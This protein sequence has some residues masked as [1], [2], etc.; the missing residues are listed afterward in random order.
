MRVS[1]A[2]VL[3][4]LMHSCL[5]K[6]S[7]QGNR[8]LSSV[9]KTRS[10]RAFSQSCGRRGRS[11]RIVGGG[12]ASLAEWPWQVSLRQYSRGGFKHKCG[13]ALI[14]Q[15]WIITAAHCVKGRRPKD[16]LVRLG[17][18]NSRSSRDGSRS[19]E[20]DIAM[21]E[22]SP[23][24]YTKTTGAICL[25]SSSS[26][27]VG[28]TGTVTGWGRTSERGSTASVLREVQVPIISNS[29]CERMYRATGQNEYIP[30]IFLCAGTR[31]RD[32]CDGDSGGPLVVKGRNGRYSLEGI[33]S[34]GIGCGARN[35]PGVYTRI[36]Q[37]RTWIQNVLRS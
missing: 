3:A 36:A 18:Y 28:R 20:N 34:W 11:G 35:R 7:H 37:F 17:E 14:S 33:I 15:R 32:S 26:S 23:V 16:L 4:V 22:V 29:Q 9:V 24:K 8:T 31:G 25:P 5:S 2:L 6:R 1:T 27:L 19:Y 13:A 30:N 12:T 21:L 10:G